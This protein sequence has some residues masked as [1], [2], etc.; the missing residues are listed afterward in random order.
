MQKPMIQFAGRS[1]LLQKECSGGFNIGEEFPCRT[2][3]S[4]MT[5]TMQA[6]FPPG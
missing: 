6:I 3:A 5:E 4:R 1:F 2:A